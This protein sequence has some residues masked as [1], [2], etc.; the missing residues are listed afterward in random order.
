[1]QLYKN[2]ACNFEQILK[3]RLI[4]FIPYYNEIIDPGIY[5]LNIFQVSL[6]PQ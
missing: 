1:M 5:V 6:N 2:Y 3:I 4:F